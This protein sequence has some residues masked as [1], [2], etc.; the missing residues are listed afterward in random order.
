MSEFEA[1]Q[2]KIKIFLGA[3]LLSA[4]QHREE[5]EYVQRC[6]LLADLALHFLGLPAEFSYLSL[7]VSNNDETAE[8]FLGIADAYIRNL[9]KFRTAQI[10][11]SPTL[12]TSN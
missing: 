1:L 8:C 11:D 3:I 4:S 6:C 2:E 5:K 10:L 9:P 12:K 7:A